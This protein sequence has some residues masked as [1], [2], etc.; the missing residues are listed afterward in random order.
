MVLKAAVLDALGQTPQLREFAEPELHGDE[1]LVTVTAAP[2]KQLDRAIAAGT[3]YSSPKTLPVVCG[4]DGA[5]RMADGSRVY[6]MVHRRPFGTMAERAPAEWTVPLPD[7]LDDAVAAAVVNPAIAAWLPLLWRAQMKPGENVLVLGATGAAG[8]MAVRAARLLGAGRVV[9]AG[10]RQEVL[11]SLD[12]DATI[13]LRLPAAD[14]RAAFAREAA[15]GLGIILDY[16]WGPAT[17]ILLDVLM[18]SDLSDDARD[19]DV[20]LVALGAMAAPTIALPSTILRASRLTILG[21]GSGNFP[22]VPRLK[23]M[24]SDILSRAARG[25]IGVD[26]VCRPLE[27]VHEVWTATE[28]GDHRLVLC[29]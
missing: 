28:H 25:E 4:T 19:G 5:G 27:R 15:L 8:R 7:P 2:L 3:H 18:K 29:W 9:A 20:R 26:V 22:P 14:L 24:V 21:S 12:A 23:S 6:F 11:R 1:V 13:D 17:E 10:R 16:V